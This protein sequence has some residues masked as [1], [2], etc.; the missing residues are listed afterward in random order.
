MEKAAEKVPTKEVWANSIPAGPFS[1]GRR[2]KLEQLIA[3]AR[4]GGFA[5]TSQFGPFS[6]ET[7]VQ[8]M[9]EVQEAAAAEPIPAPTI[10]S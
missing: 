10:E 3:F 8:K 7:L 4:Q 1:G 6:P 2:A 9:R 5:V